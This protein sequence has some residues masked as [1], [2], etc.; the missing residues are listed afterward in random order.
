ME[1]NLT[2]DQKTAVKQ[3]D[4]EAFSRRKLIER[5]TLIFE[6]LKSIT[7]L[8]RG[9]SLLGE[10]IVVRFKS[11]PTYKA[12]DIRQAFCNIFDRELGSDFVFSKE[13]EDSWM[14]EHYKGED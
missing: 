7:T 10:Y 11:I 6:Q 14:F 5:Q 9:V 3:D 8:V 1:N 2:P 12:G 13:T 4:A